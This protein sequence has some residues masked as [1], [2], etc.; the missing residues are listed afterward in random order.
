MDR[1]R[2]FLT[3]LANRPKLTALA[4]GFVS[5]T[6]FQPLALWPLALVGMGGLF[7]LLWGRGWREAGLLGWIFGVAHFTLA[8]SWIATAFTYQANMP[9]VLGWA[10]VPLLSLYLAVYPALGA[11]GARLVARQ[12]DGWPF[13]LAFA[14]CWIVSEWLRSWV[15]TG[16]AW[17]P[18]GIVLLGG[19]STPGM[20]AL[21]PWM[22]TYALSGLAVLIACGGT[23]AL[24]DKRMVALGFAAALLAAGMLIPVGKG[25][26]GTLRYTLV[27]PDIRQEVL[28]DSF[29]YYE[30]FRKT[31]NLSLPRERGEQRLVVWP[32][33]GIREYLEEG[34]PQRAYDAANV[35]RDPALTRA[36]LAQ[37]VGPGGMLIT[38]TNDL[39]F[40][41]G[42]L[43]G[44]YNA[45]KA[46]N[47]EG[48]IA[49]S[50]AKAHLVPYGEYL[51]L[52]WLL[53]PLGATR[54]V[55]GSI[56]FL[57]GP[58]PQ[59][60][61]LGPWG[62][63]GVQVCYE[64]V[65]SGQVVDR[66]N[67]PDYIW[68]G[69]NDGWFGDFGPPQHL[70][71]ARLRAVEEGLPVLRPTTT[72]ISAV[73]DA[74]GVVRDY[75]PMHQAGRLDGVIPPAFEPTLFARLGNILPLGW[76]VV[77]LAIAAIAMRRSRV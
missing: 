74:R 31:A 77:L 65:F 39:V 15:F 48:E 68:N 40:E 41:D 45:I 50:Y 32:E 1:A 28:N 51:P 3:L 42:K 47:D 62:K 73:I 2:S 36:S 24:R 37:V 56:D 16:Y 70:A 11:L 76:A 60:M 4:L 72:G 5:A 64:I 44:A 21:A 67:R 27:Q 19:L 23:L 10:A 6:G 59:T 63:A 7:A 22:G 46:V 61:D 34:Y 17:D 33:S 66:D 75:I 18:F 14:A 26:E 52:R 20:A 57:P 29:Y 55:P 54:L 38:G 13:A 30:N 25:P 43:A 8:N 49:G 71:Q 9:A 12:N 69:S 53:E 58:G 35:L